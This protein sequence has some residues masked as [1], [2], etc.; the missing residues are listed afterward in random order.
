MQLR[1]HLTLLV[2]LAACGPAPVPNAPPPDG[3]VTDLIDGTPGLNDIE[4]DHCGA[5]AFDV[6]L[7]EPVAVLQGVPIS[8]EYRVV[9][10]DGIV[11]QEYNAY[12]INFRLN[13]RGAIDRVD[14][15]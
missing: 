13:G 2:V 1:Y 5:A 4:P 6:Y 11:T 3:D 7:G 10:F 14:C 9:P 12:R 15:G 8:R